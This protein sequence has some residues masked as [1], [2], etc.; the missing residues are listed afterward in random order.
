[1]ASLNSF[2]G[3]PGSLAPTPE[4]KGGGKGPSAADK[5]SALNFKKSRRGSVG[6][7]LVRKRS[8]KVASL[9]NIADLEKLNLGNLSAT[10]KDGG[11]DRMAAFLHAIRAISSEIR[12][13]E[14]CAR[15]ILEICAL[16]QCE[17][18]SIFFVDADSNELILV[19][20]EGANNITLPIG[21][22]L[23]GTCA[24]EGKT[25]NVK[26]A[27]SDP[28]FS[29]GHDLKT[30][31]L[32]KSVL[33]VPVLDPDGS[34][35]AVL[36]LI[37][38]KSGTFSRLDQIL[39]ENMAMHTGVV[40]RN[41]KLFEVENNSRIKVAALLDVVKML[42]SSNRTTSSLI[43]A[44][45][46]RSHD[47]VDAERC[48]LYLVDRAREQLVV[49]QGDVDIRIGLTQGIAGHVATTEQTVVVEDAYKDHRFCRDIDQRS[50]FRTRSVLCLPVMGALKDGDRAV[51]GV[52]QVI[53]KFDG[54]FTADDSE[55]LQTL[56]NIAGPILEGSAQFMPAPAPQTTEIQ[57]PSTR[58]PANSPRNNSK[59][60]P[61]LRAPGEGIAEGPSRRFLD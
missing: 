19:I 52:L 2:L 58:S 14:A 31:Y 4:G 42:H 59:F 29:R 38:K 6:D 49:M 5:R 55:L 45:S 44:L 56:L 13:D 25:I 36:Q 41:A 47:I 16:V 40:L 26:D 37:N 54:T 30:G 43:F 61:K 12:P 21:K 1:M 33:C 20:A 53:N 51:I 10:E 24:A 34:I 28:R 46:N 11:W 3:T 23:A 22:G 50:G 57:R 8:L 7:L 17:R 15:V 32:T 35:V 48:S 39:T 27:Y 18:A 60:V 9:G